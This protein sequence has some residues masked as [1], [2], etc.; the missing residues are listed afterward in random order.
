LPESDKLVNEVRGKSK[1]KDCSTREHDYP[2]DLSFNGNISEQ[3]PDCSR[4]VSGENVSKQMSPPDVVIKQH[5]VGSWLRYNFF[6]KTPAGFRFQ[7]AT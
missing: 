6:I 2:Q 7:A 3:H 1:N 4:G 5:P